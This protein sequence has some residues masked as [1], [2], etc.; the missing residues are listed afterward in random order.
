[1]SKGVVVSSLIY[2]FLEGKTEIKVK[3]CTVVWKKIRGTCQH[4]EQTFPFKQPP[5]I[6]LTKEEAGIW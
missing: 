1:M 4:D 3:E 2:K 5:L 6:F